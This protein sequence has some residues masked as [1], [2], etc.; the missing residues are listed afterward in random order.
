MQMNMGEVI[1][2][3]LYG[4]SHGPHVGATLTGVP[5]GIKVD[6]EGVAKAMAR[7]RP[8]GM[9]ASKRSEADEVEW[10]SGIENGVTNGQI[11]ECRIQN[12][13]VRSKDYSFLP[14]HPRPGH[15]DL[16]MMKKTNGKADLRGGGT[17]SA[18]MTAPLVAMAAVLQ[19][20]LNQHGVE[21]MAH[22][23]NIGGVEA[24]SIDACPDAYS[25]P[26]CEQL[27]CLDAE[28]AERMASLIDKARNDRDSLGSRV[29]L[30]V[31]GLPIGVGEPWFDGVE[32]ALARAMMAVPAARAVAFGHGTN[33]INMRGS[34]HNDMWGGTAEAPILEGER[35]DGALAGLAS[36]APLRLSVSL[37]PPSS[38]SRRQTTL[39]L[40]T[41]QQEPLLVK[42]RHDPV[43]APRGVAVVEGMAILVLADLM[44]RGGFLGV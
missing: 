5:A 7:R 1:Q 44:V 41:N 33:V 35:P 32:P 39:N 28:A 30:I 17:S 42:G 11:L 34:E 22:V 19:P 10:I 37:K 13:D 4:S 36:G 3:T 26:V 9:Y 38:I 20:W 40:K 24:R 43:L 21:L 8:G 2:I 14:N 6:H 31:K 18:R 23:G 29:D 12:T 25:T 15:Q 16:V 27:R